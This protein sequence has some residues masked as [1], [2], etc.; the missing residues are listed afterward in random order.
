MHVTGAPV[1][2][3]E[4]LVELILS[5]YMDPEDQTQIMMHGGKALFSHQTFLSAPEGILNA[6]F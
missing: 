5:F 2:L 4:Q 6:D 1:K 3:R